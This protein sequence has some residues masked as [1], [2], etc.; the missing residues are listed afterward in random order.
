MNT[1]IKLIEQKPVEPSTVYLWEMTE[2][3][4]EKRLKEIREEMKDD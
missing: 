4:R 3:E 1:D 2:D